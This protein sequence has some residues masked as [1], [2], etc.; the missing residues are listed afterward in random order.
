MA[1]DEGA[2]AGCTELTDV[3]LPETLESIGKGA[4]SGCSKFTEIR[5][6]EKVSEISLDAF[7]GCTAAKEIRLPAGI[8]TIGQDAFSGADNVKDV[9]F[10]GSEATWKTVKIK[11]GNEV[12]SKAQMHFAVSAEPT[13]DADGNGIIEASDARLALRCSVKL[14]VFTPEQ[15]VTCDMDKDGRVDAADARKILRLSVGLTD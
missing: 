4:F 14:E 5:I 1:V 11:T 7:E 9:Y 10:D 12:F 6:P 2:F 13:G 3:N 15:I 8:K